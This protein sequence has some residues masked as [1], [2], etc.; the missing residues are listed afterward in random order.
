MLFFYIFLK[1]N[2]YNTP[3]LQKTE[4]QTDNN[5]DENYFKET[6]LEISSVQISKTN[7]QYLFYYATATITDSIFEENYGLGSKAEGNGGAMHFAASQCYLEKT[8]FIKNSAVTGGSLCST[9]SN[10]CIVDCNFIENSAYTMGG[11]IY[12]QSFPKEEETGKYYIGS[13]NQIGGLYK[14]NT[15]S[16]V[17]GAVT[18]SNIHSVYFENVDFEE[19]N[20]K[21]N[22]GAVYSEH[23]NLKF[24]SCKIVR[25]FVGNK[26]GETID[27]YKKGASSYLL[28]GGGGLYIGT[29]LKSETISFTTVECCIMNNIAEVVYSLNNT[30][31]SGHDVMLEGVYSQWYSYYDVIPEKVGSYSFPEGSNVHFYDLNTR[32]TCEEVLDNVSFTISNI[33][34]AEPILTDEAKT[35]NIPSPTP[36]A[37]QA[38]PITKIPIFSYTNSFPT[39][40][41]KTIQTRTMPSPFPTE[42]LK[43]T[44]ELSP[45]QTPEVSP[46]KT[47]LITPMKTIIQTPIETI[48]PTPLQIP[49]QTF[50]SESLIATTISTPTI[51]SSEIISSNHPS[52][53]ESQTIT[54]SI[55]TTTNQATTQTISLSES[56]IIINSRTLTTYSTISNVVNNGTNSLTTIT[57]VTQTII[58]VITKTEFV[59]VVQSEDEK[60][61]FDTQ[62]I[63]IL[64]IIAATLIILI[65]IC[66][67]FIAHHKKKINNEN[68]Y[69]TSFSSDDF[70]A[71]VVKPVTID[72]PITRVN[73]LWSSQSSQMTTDPFKDHFEE[74]DGLISYPIELSDSN[75]LNLN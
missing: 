50:V 37:Y 4:F 67:C 8:D 38:T 2:Q 60:D 32:E 17:G 58:Q 3:I 30:R 14:S 31:R 18:F 42:S 44:P 51:Q 10:L 34:P 15:C 71:E 74:N 1:Y 20:A 43:N 52:L 9:I 47:P 68:D 64:S 66:V 7:R 27:K 5:T 65:V 48:K 23:S 40:N 56:E 25:N 54:N 19:N 16:G 69:S 12:C 29:N 46:I 61:K 55:T 49:S 62:L 13:F 28:S 33:S 39:F 72:V 53:I 22:G 75:H 11:A 6:N 63:W 59:I 35:L 41:F 26:K 45:H 57:Y 24:Y 70:Q 21:R 36:F 73:S